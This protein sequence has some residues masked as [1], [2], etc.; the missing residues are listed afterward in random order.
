M[1]PQRAS[2]PLTLSIRNFAHLR[3]VTIALGDLTVLVGPQGAGKGLALQWLKAALDGR[4]L[5][6]TLRDAGYTADNPEHAMDLIFGH[7]MAPA[8]REGETEIKFAGKTVTPRSLNRASTREEKLFF[9]PA[10]RSLLISDGWP[11]PFQ[12]LA[13]DMPAVVRLFSQH[14]FNQLNSEGRGESFFIEA[15]L[16]REVQDQLKTSVFHGGKMSIDTNA[17]HRLSLRLIHD[18]TRLPFRAWSAGQQEL[19]PLLLG[20]RH[21][22]VHKHTGTEWV[23]LED[24]ERGLHPQAVTTILLVV[25]DLLARGY[26]VV[27]STH[28][29]CILDMVWM[30]RRVRDNEGHWALVCKALGATPTPQMQKVTMPALKKDLRVHLLAFEADGRVASQEISSLDPSSENGQEAEWGGLTASA[31]R[32]SEAVCTAVNTKSLIKS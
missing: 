13:S 18:K 23:V 14:L 32:C 5:I 29:P 17:L 1:S 26:R 6:N 31:A 2:K 9:V 30:L 12:K 20:L 15:G 27:L 22:Q 21:L 10:Q 25:L 3:D 8:W 4:H 28:S 11:A 24:P 7:G 19:T 16:Q